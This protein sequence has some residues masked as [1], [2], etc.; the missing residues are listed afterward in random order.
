MKAEKRG[1]HHWFVEPQNPQ[2][3]EVLMKNQEFLS[4]EQ[5]FEGV[6]CEDGQRH[7]MVECKDYAFISSL[8]RLKKQLDLK[9]QIWHRDGRG[10]IRV[11]DFPKKK[12]DYRPVVKWA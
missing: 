1:L 8:L 4:E 7:S 9:F 11:W 6:K 2:T 12:S 5:I 3:N 10:K